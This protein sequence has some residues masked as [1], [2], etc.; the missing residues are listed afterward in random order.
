MELNK[1][2][3]REYDIRGIYPNDINEEVAYYVGR[4]Y[5]TKLLSFGKNKCIVGYDNRSSSE[6]IEKNLIRGLTDSGVDVVRLGLVTTPM[7]YYAWDRLNI[8]C[9]IMITASHNPKEY[10]GFKISFSKIGNAYGE[11]ITDFKN[12]T[13]AGIFDDGK[14]VEIKENIKETLDNATEKVVNVIDGYHIDEKISNT[15]DK[16][17]EATRDLK[18][19]LERCTFDDAESSYLNLKLRRNRVAHDYINGL[20]DTFEDLQKFYNKAIIYVVAL[21][22]SIISL[23][24]PTT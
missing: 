5:A 21:E 4:A 14:G 12:F 15:I 18:D 22:L 11:A 19:E 6:S 1:A 20:S 2:I 7:Y 10:N 17:S 9:G 3:F 8:K 23:T 16:V 24:A 13:E